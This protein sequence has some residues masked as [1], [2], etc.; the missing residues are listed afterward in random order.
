MNS[1]LF[2][3]G[4]DVLIVANTGDGF[5]RKGVVSICNMDLSAKSVDDNRA[6]DDEVYEKD[7]IV[8][9]ISNKCI[10]KY[11]IDINNL[12]EDVSRESGA[13]KSYDG[14][15]VLELL[16]NA[17]DAMNTE[18]ANTH[19][20]GTK[21]LGFKSVLE[22]TDEPEI[23]SGDFCFH[24]SK[25]KSR[26]VLKSKV[27]KW[28]EENGIPV[29]RIPH[30]KEPDDVI[31]NLRD[32]G[33]STVI[34]LP[35]NEGKR[36][37][38]ENEL[39]KFSSN[40]LLFCQSLESVE[41]RTNSATRSIKVSRQEEG[42]SIELNENGKSTYWRAW[43][44]TKEVEG[45]KQ[46]SVSVCLPKVDG[47]GIG[48]F[49]EAPL[50][51]FFPTAECV[52]EV[53]A[54]IHASCE[55]EDNRK[56]LATRQSHRD[57]I[58]EMLEDIT[59]RILFEIPAKV[60]L[61]AFGR[62]QRSENSEMTAQLGNAIATVVQEIA[63][64][65][66][67]GGGMAK[68]DDVRLWDCGFGEEVDPAEVQDKNLCHPDI[69]DNKECFNILEKLGAKLTPVLDLAFLLRFCRNKTAKECLSAWNVA[70]LLMT[71]I[72]SGE[73]TDC[74][75]KLRDAPFWLAQNKQARAASGAIP[76][77]WEKP[78][79]FPNWLPVDVV[80]KDF[81]K[82]VQGEIKQHKS[83]DKEWK[84]RLSSLQPLS[85]KSYFEHILLPHC[86]EQSPEW[87]R[88]NGW[89]AL[90]MAFKWGE[91][92]S[93]DELLIIDS[94]NAKENRANIF[95]LPV[96]K[97]AQEWVPAGKCYGGAAWGGPKI[98]DKYF[99]KISERY[100]LSSVD[101]WE[102]DISDAD[103]DQWKSLLSWLGCSWTFKMKKSNAPHPNRDYINNKG[104]V[105]EFCFE[106]F[107]DVFPDTPIGKKSDYE[108]V[109]NMVSGMHES[110]CK[111]KAH[112]LYR[113]NKPCDSY[114]LIQLQSQAWIPCK[115]SLLYPNK[116]LFKPADT[117]L[118]GC[119]LGGLLPEVLKSNDDLKWAEVKKVLEELGANKSNKPEK[120]VE[121][122]NDLSEIN[123]RNKEDFVWSKGT[124]KSK[125]KI[126][127]AATAIFSAYAE[128][129]HTK[130][131]TANVMI[132]CLRSTSTGVVVY[133]HK[134][135]EAYWANKSYFN[136]PVVR[137]K[138]LENN[139]LHIFFR[140][141]KDGEKFDLQEL[142]EFLDM[143]PIYGA[144]NLQDTKKLCQE[145][146]KRRIGLMKATG[147]E[148]PEQLEI[149]AYDSITL[150]AQAHADINPEIKFWKQSEDKVAIN[151]N[152]GMW[153]GLAAALGDVAD[154]AQYKPDF[155]LLLTEKT[156]DG[157]LRR[158]R[159]DYGL[160]EESI[161]KVKEK[162]Y[163]EEVEADDDAI[164]E[165]NPGDST[166]ELPI[167]DSTSDD[168]AHSR[169]NVSND[170]PRTTNTRTNS[171]NRSDGN[172]WSSE[173]PD[174]PEI[175]IVEY[176]WSAERNLS[177]GGGWNSAG[178]DEKETNATDGR[179][180]EEALV[181]WLE[182]KYGNENVTDKNT[183]HTNNP[184]Y[185]ILVEKDGEK[186]Y[187]ECKSFVSVNPPR[188]VSITKTQHDLAKSEED[189]YW[190]CVVYD[191]NS[192]PVKMLHPIANP[193]ALEKEATGYKINIA[194][195]SRAPIA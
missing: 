122:M 106:H 152:I 37:F 19:L 94:G 75:E 23:Y 105:N 43:R 116:Y 29:C 121:H 191:I 2:D 72:D 32:K 33:Y 77:V 91:K 108:S 86:K 76:L 47:K 168:D 16:Q 118:P 140:F 164:G 115:P 26:E 24:F 195:R 193:A 111:S 130:P 97:D 81:W 53:R 110:A 136:E 162:I 179:P 171:R 147:Q 59:Q 54:L 57:E 28:K 161:E 73:K 67:I 133:F 187:Y 172:G 163:E 125:G 66:L 176:Q 117:Y 79:G 165:N 35:L 90:E 148:L 178:D 157:F 103:K 175:E 185:D 139:E 92:E 52:P 129:D 159:D 177:G 132:P 83:K 114:A 64:I 183:L 190:L 135:G 184:G 82:C 8:R 39:S 46:L 173:R 123:C 49:T 61:R 12:I 192:N 137:R 30:N 48:G 10:E 88:K 104:W 51:V 158:L 15:F 42:S 71:E 170:R 7:D 96:G 58:C 27:S 60:A 62:A 131:L 100:V 4:D 138:I 141:L 107:D 84:N 69:N 36:E 112:Y 151:V 167:S 181:E 155:E 124:S 153:Q 145:Y 13:S 120:L 186:H 6:P 113:T 34:R 126:A 80:D 25:Q 85:E 18:R 160:P 50:Y 70:Q 149:V 89:K 180:A 102:T 146:S 22:I 143:Q 169:S 11:K 44:E 174:I 55:V 63:F 98:F 150:E 154:C 144:K 87:W 78:K 166:I 38:V 31:Q 45:E 156:W 9:S 40:S 109:L 194:N 65:P 5:S 134:S 128:I 20:I 142:S 56:H 119:S 3:I 99:A 101:D 189:R 95:C 14:R 188:R 93:E 74:E 182:T 127:R 41:I 17:D 1:I 68:P 21:G